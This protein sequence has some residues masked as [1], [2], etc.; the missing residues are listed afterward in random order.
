M[1]CPICHQNARVLKTLGDER[2][3]ECTQCKHRF[4]TT[5]VLK[6]E[7]RRK[8]QLLRDARELAERLAA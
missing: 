4:T 8:D 2:R 6:D 5:E 7:L 1:N 3:R